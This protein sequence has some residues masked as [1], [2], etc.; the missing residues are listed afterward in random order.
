MQ[1]IP[2]HE[3]NT[4]LLC[5]TDCGSPAALQV[6]DQRIKGRAGLLTA[7]SGFL[8]EVPGTSSNICTPIDQSPR[9]N[10][11]TFAPGGRGEEDGGG[12]GVI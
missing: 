5:V 12:R 6:I 1:R 3:D 11:R 8:D 2:T 10:K 4:N 7:F 9:V